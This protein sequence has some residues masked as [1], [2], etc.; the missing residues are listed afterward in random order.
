MPFDFTQ[1]KNENRGPVFLK[2]YFIHFNE[3]F[4][5]EMK[6]VTGLVRSNFHQHRSCS[7][8]FPYV[9]IIQSKEALL[10]LQWES[11]LKVNEANC[12]LKTK[13]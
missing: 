10:K 12:K 6:I 3:R 4:C 11:L 5:I 8:C 7:L 13:S 1:N 9:K 2:F